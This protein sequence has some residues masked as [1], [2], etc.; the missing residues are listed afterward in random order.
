MLPCGVTAGHSAATE[1]RPMYCHHCWGQEQCPWTTKLKQRAG[2]LPPK[3]ATT[4]GSQ[5]RAGAVRC[6]QAGTNSSGPSSS[7]SSL[8]KERIRGSHA[9]CGGVLR[10]ATGR[11]P[12]C[13][14][15]AIG[16]GAGRRG[17]QAWR[18]PTATLL[19]DAFQ[20]H[21]M[22]RM[23]P[24]PRNMPTPAQQQ[25]SGQLRGPHPSRPPASPPRGPP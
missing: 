7:V 24:T 1:R 10:C 9:I 15:P 8:S 5:R 22:P 20:E 13:S 14:T 23:L 12:P 17:E 21:F 6:Q 3:P 25:A 19:R 11:A 18:G 4:T 2:R 16:S